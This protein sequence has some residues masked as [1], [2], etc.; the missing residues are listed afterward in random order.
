MAK[1]K[2]ESIENRSVKVCR[3]MGAQTM[4]RLSQLLHVKQQDLQEV[5]QKSRKLQRTGETW[6]VVR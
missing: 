2:F 4:Q 3:M 6:D 5:L 1:S